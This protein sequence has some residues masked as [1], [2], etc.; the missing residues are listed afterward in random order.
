[1]ERF[2]GRCGGRVAAIWGLY[3]IAVAALTGAFSDGAAPGWQA[4]AFA[5][6]AGYLVFAWTE[7]KHPWIV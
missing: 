5:L 3:A 6:G 7:G 2:E 1:V 4:W